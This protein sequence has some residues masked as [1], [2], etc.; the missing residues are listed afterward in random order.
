MS[1][2]RSPTYSAGDA[3]Q[4]PA[5]PKRSAADDVP[6]EGLGKV[7]GEQDD[8]PVPLLVEAPEG[9]PASWEPRLTA[10]EVFRHHAGRIFAVARR[11]LG[12]DA[13]AEDGTA[14]V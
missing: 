10:E 2:M 13:D 5:G 8:L 3:P 9:N 11:M 1:T 6:T 14:E 7:A 12:N 4:W